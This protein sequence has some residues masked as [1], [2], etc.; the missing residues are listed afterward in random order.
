MHSK[1]CPALAKGTF[2]IISVNDFKI[3]FYY[4]KEDATFYFTDIFI[5]IFYFILFVYR[6][7]NI[8]NKH[9]FLHEALILA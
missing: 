9:T 6:F 1:N 2:N 5:N 3:Y 8:D 7:M 4:F